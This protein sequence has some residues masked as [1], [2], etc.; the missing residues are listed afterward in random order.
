MLLSCVIFVDNR[1]RDIMNAKIDDVI[2]NSN[3]I[4]TITKRLKELIE[5]EEQTALGIAFGR[6]YN[7]FHYQTRR[8]LKRDATEEEFK[9]FVEILS[10]RAD[11]IKRALQKHINEEI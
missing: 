5:D 2:N 4:V 9:E 11:K 7:A 3:E 10:K 8:V 1:I 6:I